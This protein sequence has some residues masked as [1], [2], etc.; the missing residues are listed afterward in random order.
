ME[1][2]QEAVNTKPNI[3]SCEWFGIILG[4]QIDKRWGYIK[5]PEKIDK[6]L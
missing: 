1:H 6:K 2:S 4:L 3:N 5:I